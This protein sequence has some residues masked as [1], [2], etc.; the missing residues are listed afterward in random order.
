MTGAVVLRPAGPSDA[1]EIA[2]LH[3]AVWR[4]TYAGLAPADAVARL[5]GAARLERWRAHLAAP[6]PG[7]GT[8]LALVEDRLAGFVRYGPAGQAELEPGGE[9][10][11]LYVDGAMAGRGLGR[12]LLYAGF[13]ALEAAG[14]RE[15]GLAVVAGNT[16][17]IAFYERL[18]GV[19]SG[20]FRDAGPV[21][22]SDNLV[23][24]WTLGEDT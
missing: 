15:A 22:R 6:G 16:R 24:R 13:D 5:D 14:F 11:S 21:W 3:V 18:G 19:L 12:R 8:I 2:R 23:Y 7:A 4:A 20:R 10:V 17:A 9:I 1:P